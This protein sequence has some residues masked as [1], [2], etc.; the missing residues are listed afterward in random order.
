MGFGDVQRVRL[1]REGFRVQKRHDM[2]VLLWE[3]P[4]QMIMDHLDLKL[5]DRLELQEWHR[6]GCNGPSNFSWSHW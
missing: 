2:R 5:K 6:G 4:V 3:I 1:K